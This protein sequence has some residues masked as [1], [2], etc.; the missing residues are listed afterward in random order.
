M[1]TSTLVLTIIGVTYTSTLFM[2]IIEWLDAPPRTKKAPH[3]ETPTK[4]SR[5]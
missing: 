2:R 5:V 1:P 4:A 3:P